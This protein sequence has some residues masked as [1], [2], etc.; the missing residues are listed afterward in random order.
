MRRTSAVRISG[1]VSFPSRAMFFNFVTPDVVCS[2]APQTF[3]Q[4]LPSVV[5]RMRVSSPRSSTRSTGSSSQAR[6]RFASNSAGD[7]SP[8]EK[9]VTPS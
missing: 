5:C 4:R 7:A 3:A 2:L 8:T 9:T 6:V 1:D